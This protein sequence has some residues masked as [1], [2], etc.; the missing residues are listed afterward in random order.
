MEYTLD[1]LEPLL[2][3]TLKDKRR[4]FHLIT[5]AQEN[6]EILQSD[7]NVLLP[8]IRKKNRINII[9]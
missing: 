7:S 1:S 3:E 8:K 5:E 2:E 4:T 6:F 9:P